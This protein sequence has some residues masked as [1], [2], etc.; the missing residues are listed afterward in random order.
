MKKLQ[1]G[2]IGWAGPEEYPKKARIPKRVFSLAEKVGESIARNDCILITGGKGGIMASAAKGAK[3]I[4]GI[5]LGVIQ[6]DQRYKSNPDTDVEILTGA[7]TAG[8][9]EYLLV[10]ISDALIVIGGGQGL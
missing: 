7:T 5:T 10:M 3:K 9:D 6:G 4:G 1:I 2:V 8:L